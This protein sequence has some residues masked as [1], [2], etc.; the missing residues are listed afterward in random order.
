[1]HEE[2]TKQGVTGPL[3]RLCETGGIGT[4]WRRQDLRAFFVVLPVLRVKILLSPIHT[5]AR[6]FWRAAGSGE[7]RD[8]R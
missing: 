2:C 4:A 6:L 7:A 1:M 3:P 8:F 5:Q